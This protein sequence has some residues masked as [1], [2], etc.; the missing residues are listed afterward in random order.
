MVNKKPL[1]IA[2]VLA[3][4]AGVLA[5][6]CCVLP[7]VFAIIGAGSVTFAAFLEPYRPYLLVVAYLAIAAA[8]YYVN[9]NKA[10]CK[11]GSFCESGKAQR[12][13]KI[14]LWVL[15]IAVTL[16]ATF[17]YWFGLFV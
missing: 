10:A 2:S 11:E 7:V 3:L 16:V 8:F 1:A 14:F 9:K 6:A 17:P 15:F 12:S 5:S 4:A 13:T